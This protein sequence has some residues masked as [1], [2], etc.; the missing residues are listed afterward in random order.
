MIPLQVPNVLGFIFGVVQMA[1]YFMYR[2]AKKLIQEAEPAVVVG[3]AKLQELTEQIIDVVKLSTIMC[4][5]L[6]PVLK[7]ITAS[8]HGEDHDDHQP[9]EEAALPKEIEQ[10]ADNING[11]SLQNANH[12]IMLEVIA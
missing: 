11:D 1:L 7:D 8:V 4:P 10:C 12:K 9:Q 6:D 2:N 5:E 3:N